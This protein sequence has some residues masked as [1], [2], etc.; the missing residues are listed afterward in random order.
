W[1]AAAIFGALLWSAAYGGV[2]EWL[3]IEALRAT[4]DE[5]IPA[6][7]QNDVVLLTLTSI[8]VVTFAP[9][10]EETFFRGFVFPGLTKWGVP[11]AVAVS[12]GLFGIAH[13]NYKALVPILGIGMVFALAYLKSGNILTTVIAHFAF[14]C[15][16][17]TTL[18]AGDCEPS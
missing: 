1:A 17:V 5:Q 14:N 6:D 15:I 12:A 4:C 3:D 9:V 8:F 18:W 16:S 2:N 11:V 7:V 10:C 13:A